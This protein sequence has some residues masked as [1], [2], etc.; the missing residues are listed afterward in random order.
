MGI[1]GVGGPR[2]PRPMSGPAK[3]PQGYSQIGNSGVWADK[4]AKENGNLDG[5]VAGKKSAEQ[6][7]QMLN[8]DAKGKGFEVVPGT[9]SSTGNST[10]FE[11][12]MANPFH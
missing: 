12:K 2:A 9:V 11:L 4:Y 8:K 5:W 7:Q 10:T 1:E 3:P 6:I